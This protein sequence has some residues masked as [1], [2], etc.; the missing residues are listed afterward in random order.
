MAGE[1]FRK[2]LQGINILNHNTG[3]LPSD[4]KRT[5][6]KPGRQSRNTPQLCLFDFICSRSN[7]ATRTASSLSSA[8]A[9]I[10]LAGP[11]SQIIYIKFSFTMVTCSFV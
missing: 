7:F 9:T 8:A 3:L 2:S 10:S 4:V 1:S 6:H 11:V 5:L